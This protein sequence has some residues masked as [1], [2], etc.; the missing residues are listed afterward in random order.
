[1]SKKLAFGFCTVIWA[2]ALASC[3]TATNTVTSPSVPP[4]NVVLIGWD[5]AQREHVKECIERGGLPALG[6][7]AT[8][9]S[10][11]NID[12]RGATDTTAGWAQILT[13]YDPDVTGAWSNNKF[14]PIPKGLSLFERLKQQFGPNIVTMAVIAKEHNLGEI[15]PPFKI[16]I[17]EPN[18]NTTTNL[19]PGEP[20]TDDE[21]MSVEQIRSTRIVI[22]DG[23]KY[24]VYPGSPWLHMKDSCDHWVYGLGQN[25]TVTTK[26]LELLEQYKDKP[27]F[28]F[29]HFAEA[30][31][32]GHSFGENSPEYT[33]GLVSNDTSTA[34]ITEKL[35][36]LGIYDKTYVYVTADHGFDEDQKTH[37]NAS[38]VFI[39][40]NDP[41]VS[42]DGHR[43]DI[44]PTIL[45]RFG[46]DLAKFTPPFAGAPLDQQPKH[47]ASPK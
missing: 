36:Q 2:I 23:V 47:P 44:A 37:R 28:L 41:R 16:R 9:G 3:T 30:D 25:E 18:T 45:K 26:A 11:R 8:R 24:R 39:V 6:T 34:R 20:P 38:R 21:Y 29:V 33:A 4:C 14:G 17:A 19:S 31:R 27:F 12:I 43:A 46:L 22:E 1:M 13:G 7:L 42:R 40:T 35:K 10:F 32:A 5:G 15:R